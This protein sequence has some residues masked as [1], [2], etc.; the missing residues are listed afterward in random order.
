M[1]EAPRR[2]EKP[3]PP[4]FIVHPDNWQAFCLF[5]DLSTQ[6]RVSATV[7]GVIY[8]GLDYSSVHALLSIQVDRRK[9][10]RA[11]FEQIRLIEIGALRVI[12]DRENLPNDATD[13]R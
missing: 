11:L 3:D 8:Q 6:W 13:P 10:R 2:K 12:N 9:K 4:S 1:A 7:S 5:L